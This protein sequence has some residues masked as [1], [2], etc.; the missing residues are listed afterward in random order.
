MLCQPQCET[1]EMHKQTMPNT[2]TPAAMRPTLA[3]QGHLCH[4]KKAL[5]FSTRLRHIP[6]TLGENML[7]FHLNLDVISTVPPSRRYFHIST[8][9]LVLLV[10]TDAST[11]S[12][13]SAVLH[14]LRDI[15]PTHA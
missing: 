15:K 11:A 2:L 6:S 5:R 4:S 3:Q 1:G 8:L 14:S 13:I 7:W 12:S 9:M 10:T